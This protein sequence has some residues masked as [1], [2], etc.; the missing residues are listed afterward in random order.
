MGSVS[1]ALW[2]EKA[3]NMVEKAIDDIDIINRNPIATLAS[4]VGEI[5]FRYIFLVESFALR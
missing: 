4:T 2:A 3:E 5:T 1:Q